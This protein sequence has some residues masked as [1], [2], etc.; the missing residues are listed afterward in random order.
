MAGLAV[1]VVLKPEGT[2]DGEGGKHITGC[3]ALV[4]GLLWRGFT[5]AV[6]TVPPG[7]QRGERATVLHPPQSTN[8][9][10]LNPRSDV[11]CSRS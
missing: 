11:S 9:P 1:C 10:S 7:A 5:G 2:S 4:G 3:G 6:C 8:L